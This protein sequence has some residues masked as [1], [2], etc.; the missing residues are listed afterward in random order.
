MIIYKCGKCGASWRAG[1]V[2]EAHDK[3]CLASGMVKDSKGNLVHWEYKNPII[4]IKV[5]DLRV[6]NFDEPDLR[7]SDQVIRALDRHIGVS[8]VYRDGKWQTYE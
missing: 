5:Y 1:I 4:E 7:H 2:K 3:V 6:T 8:E